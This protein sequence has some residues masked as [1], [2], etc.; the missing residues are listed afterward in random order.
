MAGCSYCGSDQYGKSCR[1]APDAVPGL[2]GTHC[3]KGGPGC[4]WCGS[5]EYGQS[6]REA[7][8]AVPGMFGTHEHG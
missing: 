4:I 3:H 8:D 2:F 7:P 6:C 1:D 5:D